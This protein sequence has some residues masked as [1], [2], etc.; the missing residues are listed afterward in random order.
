MLNGLMMAAAGGVEAFDL[1]FTTS[2]F[3]AVDRTT[4][5]FSSQAI[6]DASA[7]R[8]VIVGATSASG[9]QTVSSMTIGGISASLIVSLGDS[10][11]SGYRA[12]LWAAAVPTGTTADVVVTYSGGVVRCGI[13][14]WRMVGGSVTPTD[15]A[16]ASADPA[17]DTINVAA[18]GGLCAIVLWSNTGA[19]YTTSWTGVDEDFDTNFGEGDTNYSGGSKLY[20]AAQ[21]GMTISASSDGSTNRE[22]MVAAS[23]PP[24]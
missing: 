23:F 6:G 9:S 7:S 3:D 20:A 5:T 19:P 22:A 10:V 16:S 8:Y 2:A 1:A 11:E 21:T 4:Y 12:E 18:G 13:G 24:A 14:I 15:T 17:S